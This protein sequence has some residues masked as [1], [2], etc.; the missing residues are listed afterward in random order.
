MCT[1]VGPAASIAV[2]LLACRA[3]HAVDF[4]LKGRT[5]RSRLRPSCGTAVRLEREP[6][7]W[8]P[9]QTSHTVL[10]MPEGGREAARVLSLQRYRSAHGCECCPRRC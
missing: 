9:I 1:I 6:S 2:E 10:G 3:G 7:R 4:A 5:P 8:P